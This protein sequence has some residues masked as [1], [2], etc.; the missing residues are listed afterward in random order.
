MF[1]I[2]YY[3]IKFIFYYIANFSPNFHIFI[4]KLFIFYHEKMHLVL[5]KVLLYIYI[6][7]SGKSMYK[8]LFFIIFVTNEIFKILFTRSK[9]NRYYCFV[10]MK[11]N[12][13]DRSF[14]LMKFVFFNFSVIN[15][16]DFT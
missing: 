7:V 5:P 14:T 1:C 2:I 13:R 9:L 11:I 6:P 10:N 8:G 15:F 3:T 4:K 16:T 12:Y